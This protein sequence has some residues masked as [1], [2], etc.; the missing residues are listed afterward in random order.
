[1]QRQGCLCASSVAQFHQLDIRI[2]STTG[3][4]QCDVIQ[5]VWSNTEGGVFII[6]A[7]FLSIAI[8]VTSTT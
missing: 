3:V 4:R 1:M 5:M 8:D 6:F 2:E 7:S